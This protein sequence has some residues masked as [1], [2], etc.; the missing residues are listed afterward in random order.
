MYKN[1]TISNFIYNLYN[2]LYIMQNY[3]T[4]FLKY[5]SQTLPSFININFIKIC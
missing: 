5:K 4:Y 3:Y 1:Y 2:I